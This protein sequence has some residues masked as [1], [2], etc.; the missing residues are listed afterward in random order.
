MT[1]GTTAASSGHKAAGITF[2]TGR[3]VAAVL[4]R[5]H[6]RGVDLDDGTTLGA[7]AVVEAVGSVPNTEWLRGNPGLDL[8]DG[9]LC[10]NALLAAGTHC[11]VAVGDVARFP[12]PLFDTTPRRVEHWSVPGDTAKRAAATLTAL[13]A[14]AAARPVLGVCRGS[15][16]IDIAHGGT[17]IPD[18]ADH[19]LHHGGPG[20]PMFLDEKVTITPGTQVADL[21]GELRPTV[22]SGHHQAV[23]R[24]GDGL[25]VAARA[26][27][28]VVEA[29]E[30]PAR[31]VVGVQWH[32]E[33]P[34]GC[35]VHRR[36]LF[37]GFV[38]ACT[39]PR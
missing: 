31:W 16:L 24:V 8:S 10:G 34:D 13:L 5:D 1:V 28:G 32:P 27:D 17:L 15:Q 14:C 22:R 23:D 2:R 36:R 30:H 18:L 7:D 35:A 4:G 26:D 12:N 9:V 21:A 29:V 20:Q 25:V 38:T 39:G 33:D 6:V 37:S 3:S 19:R 11:L